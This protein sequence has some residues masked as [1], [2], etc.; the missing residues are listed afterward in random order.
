MHS[1]DVAT[2]LAESQKAIDEIERQRDRSEEAIRAMGFNPDKVKAVLQ[3]RI[4]PKEQ[5]EVERLVAEDLAEVDR[6]VEQ[7]KARQAFNASG[8][9]GGK[10]PRRMV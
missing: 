5:E 1:D 9:K 2:M 4:G 7:A 6:E 10:K 3:A 8:A